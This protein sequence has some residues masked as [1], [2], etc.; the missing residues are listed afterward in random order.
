[1]DQVIFAALGITPTGFVFSVASVVIV[2]L[3]VFLIVAERR[4]EGGN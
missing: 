3:C 2:A 4:A 1:M